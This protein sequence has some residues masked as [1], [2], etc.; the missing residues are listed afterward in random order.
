MPDS[1]T[2]GA[3]GAAWVM[4]DELRPVLCC[5]GEPVGGDPE[6]R[7]AANALLRAGIV[8]SELIVDSRDRVVTVSTLPAV[9]LDSAEEAAARIV[10]WLHAA[11]DR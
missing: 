6:L 3:L 5:A 2:G 9:A 8:L 10:K 1:M 7:P 11:I 4:A